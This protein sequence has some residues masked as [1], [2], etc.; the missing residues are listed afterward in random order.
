MTFNSQEAYLEAL[1]RFETY[2]MRVEDPSMTVD[3]AWETI[4]RDEARGVRDQL[5][6]ESDWAVLPDAPTDKTAWTT[7]R[8]A[9]RDLPTQEGFPLTYTLPTP[10]ES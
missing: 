8:Q 7:Y 4:K 3:A 6:K 9:L 2:D 1:K 5:L 10:P